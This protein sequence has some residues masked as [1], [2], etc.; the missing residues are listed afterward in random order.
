MLVWKYVIRFEELCYSW[1]VFFQFAIIWERIFVIWIVWIIIFFFLVI[2]LRWRLIWIS[3]NRAWR[4]W[5]GCK[6]PRSKAPSS[7]SVTNYRLSLFKNCKL[8]LLFLL[9]KRN[10]R[11]MGKFPSNLK[12]ERAW[13]VP[14]KFCS[15]SCIIYRGHLYFPFDTSHPHHEIFCF[16]NCLLIPTCKYTHVIMYCSDYCDL[17]KCS[18]SV[19][20]LRMNF[21]FLLVVLDQS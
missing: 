20:K 4:F 5:S 7:V 9:L 11:K 16:Q 1:R 14:L 21:V 8:L 2:L 10:N 19:F 17:P 3:V 15:P 12:G 18:F 13:Q 6:I